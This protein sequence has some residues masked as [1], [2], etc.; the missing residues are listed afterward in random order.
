MASKGKKHKQQTTEKRHKQMTM[1]K[2]HTRK[3]RSAAP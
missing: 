3:R 1:E 2:K